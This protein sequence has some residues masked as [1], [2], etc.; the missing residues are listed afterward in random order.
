M[1]NGA[2]IG[3]IADPVAYVAVFARQNQALHKIERATHFQ[4]DQVRCSGGTGSRSRLL[5]LSPGANVE[6]SDLR[7]Q[8]EGFMS[9]LARETKLEA[10]IRDE[11]RGLL[12]GGT[13][14]WQ[15]RLTAARL[16][17]FFC[18]LYVS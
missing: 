9:A 17:F 10:M 1:A 2:H 12:V 7:T 6:G 13:A 3:C 14:N 5:H 18:V 15:W 4:V 8:A 11:V 16:T